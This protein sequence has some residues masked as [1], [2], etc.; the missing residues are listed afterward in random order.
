MSLPMNGVSHN[1][2]HAK[3]KHNSSPRNS[4]GVG[5]MSP[6]VFSVV[7][8]LVIIVGL[9][10]VSFFRGSTFNNSFTSLSV[11]LGKKT[12]PFFHHTH[13]TLSKHILRNAD[14]NV[15]HTVD[16]KEPTQ[17]SMRMCVCVCT[18]TQIYTCVCVCVCVCQLIQG[19]F[20][21]LAARESKVKSLR[22][23][24]DQASVEL[25]QLEHAMRDVKR[26]QS[27]WFLD[28]V[29]LSSVQQIKLDIHDKIR[30]MEGLNE[31]IDSQINSL[32][33]YVTGAQR[34]WMMTTEVVCVC[35]CSLPLCMCADLCILHPLY[36]HPTTCIGLLAPAATGHTPCKPDRLQLAVIECVQSRLSRGAVLRVA[37]GCHVRRVRAAAAYVRR[38]R[39]DPLPLRIP[40][41]PDLV[42][43]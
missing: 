4:L 37:L 14:V 41:H 16:G 36:A 7:L 17:V 28:M 30:E 27:T 22:A 31:R 18:F 40:R 43:P 25:Y 23:Q 34:V 11:F 38:A 24:L 39:V 20:L 1:H 35:V 42:Q 5:L 3:S 19:G 29:S 8:L 32:K 12:P 6:R 9:M 13:A 2:K 10:A 21:D 33:P 26:N 15:I